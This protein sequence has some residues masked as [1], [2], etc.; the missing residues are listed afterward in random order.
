M[1]L[2]SCCL[3]CL[4]KYECNKQARLKVK[5]SGEM[6][7]SSAVTQRVL[8]AGT[9]IRR[10]QLSEQTQ[11]GW[12]WGGRGDTPLIHPQMLFLC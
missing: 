9:Q 12:E 1:S 6:G 3:D 2:A 7:S 11:R 5:I 8:A 4:M 10:S